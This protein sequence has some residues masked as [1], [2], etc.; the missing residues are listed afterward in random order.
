MNVHG[1]SSK[2][3]VRCALLSAACDLP[4]G[5]K[6]C[7]FLS[8]NAFY[9]CTRCWKKFPG[10]VGSRDFSGFDRD[11]WPLRKEEERRKY[12]DMLLSCNTKAQRSNIEISTG[13]RYTSLLKLPYFNP[14]RMLILDP[15][16]N[17]FFWYS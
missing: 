14:T 5:R 7:G 6:L 9:W 3:V 17:L 15:M 10:G 11:N 2:Q 4:A 8:F 16:H 12:G 1:Y 13:Y